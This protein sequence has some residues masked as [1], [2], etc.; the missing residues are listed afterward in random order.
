MNSQLGVVEVVQLDPREIALKK[1]DLYS[2]FYAPPGTRSE[3]QRL[4]TSHN[5]EW[6]LA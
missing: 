4:S 3:T 6:T 1:K 2:F 5:S